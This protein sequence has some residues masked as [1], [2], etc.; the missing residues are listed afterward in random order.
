MEPGGA[1]SGSGP[2]PVP[3]RFRLAMEPGGASSGSGPSRSVTGSV[4]V[5]VSPGLVRNVA[6]PG[7]VTGRKPVFTG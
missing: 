5:S 3:S 4:S 7:G 6:G 1:S 2:L